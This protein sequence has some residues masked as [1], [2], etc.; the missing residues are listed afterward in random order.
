MANC[1]SDGKI[2]Y[3]II[4]FEGCCRWG[5]GCCSVNFIHLLDLTRNIAAKN[6]TLGRLAGIELAA[7][8]FQCSALTN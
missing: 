5:E 6:A 3:T 2:L 4:L 1:G 8:R 7:L